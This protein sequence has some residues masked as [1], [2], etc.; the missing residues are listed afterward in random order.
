M[1][2]IQI[3]PNSRAMR[4]ETNGFEMVGSKVLNGSSLS[5][6]YTVGMLYDGKLHLNKLDSIIE[7]RPELN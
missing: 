4:Y 3:K 5:G 7:V 1:T 6:T 2:D